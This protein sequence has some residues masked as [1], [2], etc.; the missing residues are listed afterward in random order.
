MDGQTSGVMGSWGLWRCSS[1]CISISD[2]QIWYFMP[3]LSCTWTVWAEKWIF[4]DK[5]THRPTPTL[6]NLLPEPGPRMFPSFWISRLKRNHQTNG[7]FITFIVNAKTFPDSITLVMRCG[8]RVRLHT[9]DS[10]KK[11]RSFAHGV[12]FRPAA[13]LKRWAADKGDVISPAAAP[14][15]FPPLVNY[16][17]VWNCGCS[18]TLV[19]LVSYLEHCGRIFC[20][21]CLIFSFSFLESQVVFKHLSLLLYVLLTDYLN[22][23]LLNIKR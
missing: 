15:L 2:I 16:S 13:V 10:S 7:H 11:G 8:L 6:I 3:K 22:V 4:S 20:S 19:H 9:F 1:T 23:L 17:L 18:H 5:L 21:I 14:K 12:C